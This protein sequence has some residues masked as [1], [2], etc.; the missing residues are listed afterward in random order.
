MKTLF[1]A[2]TLCM[3]L[4]TGSA[5]ADVLCRI[6]SIWCSTTA[7]PCEDIEVPDG[8]RCFSHAMPA[9]M[10][11]AADLGEL[12]RLAGDGKPILLERKS[13]RARGNIVVPEAKARACPP[14]CME[15]PIVVEPPVDPN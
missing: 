8:Y 15:P 10:K 14:V 2:A 11:L 1:S 5:Q 13:G 3:A 12:S 6:G 7:Y 4:T 9:E